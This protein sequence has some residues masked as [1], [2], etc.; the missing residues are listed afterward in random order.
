LAEFPAGCVKPV[1]GFLII[2]SQ[3]GFND[4]IDHGVPQNSWPVVTVRQGQNVTIV[5][6]N[7]DAVE[8][9]GF[10]IDNYYDARTVA[11]AP[12][13][14]LTVSFVANKVGTFRIYCNIFCAI[15]WAMQSGELVV[16]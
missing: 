7:A 8:A 13:R 16:T 6:C 2:A 5:V 15:H 1:D 4:S 14:V 10:Q 3:R 11:L 12:G 9:H